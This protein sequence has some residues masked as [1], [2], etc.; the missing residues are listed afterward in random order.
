[1]SVA[2]RAIFIPGAAGVASFWTPLI[3]RLPD[4]WQT[5]AI[6]LP[7]LGPIAAVPGISGYDD[8]VEHVA[9]RI[10]QPTAVVAQSMGTY[11]ALQLAL[12]Y[13]DCVTCPVLAAATGG[14]D[15]ASH[16]AIEWRGEYASAHPYAQPWATA[17]VAD[18]TDRLHAIEV[19]VLLIW[20]TQDAFSPLSVGRVLASR[21]PD[22]RLITFP[23]DDHW[24]ARQFAD[25]AATA[26]V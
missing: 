25:D 11:I 13:P 2:T 24:V 6:D 21:L 20:A 10:P 19:P 23:T 1:M 17:Q 4:A 18:L 16:G 26:I 15:A 9:Q 7:G 3:D 8:L 14:V 5:R 22:A 12:R